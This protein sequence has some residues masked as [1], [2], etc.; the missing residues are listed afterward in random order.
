MLLYRMND[1]EM[2][3]GRVTQTPSGAKTQEIKD[4]IAQVSQPLPFEKEMSTIIQNYNARNMSQEDQKNY[5]RWQEKTATLQ[6]LE[7]TLEDYQKVSAEVI[8]LEQL[9]AGL[10][11]DIDSASDDESLEDVIERLNYLAGEA[12]TWIEYKKRR[13]LE[14]VRSFES[15]KEEA[16]KAG[17]IPYR[18]PRFANRGGTKRTRPKRTR[19]KRT[20]TKRTRTKRTRTK[21]IR[22]KTNKK[23]NPRRR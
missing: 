8:E 17:L 21:R 18:M 19:T 7:F 2:K 4:L 20:R 15:Q 12:M 16:E 14:I 11:N 1:F 13:L 3:T 22:R 10:Q 5:F 6:L 23:R 9:Y